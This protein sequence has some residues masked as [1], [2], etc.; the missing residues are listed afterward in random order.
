MDLI[1]EGLAKA[2]ELIT[3]GDPGIFEISLFTLRVSFTAIL[4]STILGIPLGILLGLTRFPGRKFLLILL[5]S[6]WAY[7]VIAG[8]TITILLWRQVL[9]GLR[10]IIYSNSHY[11]GP[12]SCF[13]PHCRRINKFFLSAN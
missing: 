13:L 3:S 11:N 7:P 5:I 1:W 2:I 12:N 10:T 8:L 6:G 4:I 9:W